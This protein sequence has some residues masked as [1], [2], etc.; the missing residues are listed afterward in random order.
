[1]AARQGAGKTFSAVDRMRM[2]SHSPLKPPGPLVA[3]QNVVDYASDVTQFVIET[4]FPIVWRG[5]NGLTFK[6]PAQV[7]VL[8]WRLGLLYIFCVVCVVA[9]ILVAA[10]LGGLLLDT[11]VPLAT[12]SVFSSATSNFVHSVQAHYNLSKPVPCADPDEFAFYYDDYFIYQNISCAFPDPM[13]VATKV[14]TR[15]MFISTHT[16]ETKLYR[17]PVDAN[18]ECAPNVTVDGVQFGDNVNYAGYCRYSNVQSLLQIGSIETDLTFSHSYYGELV[19]KR[20]MSPKTYVRRSG[21]TSNRRT[22]NGGESVSMTVSEWL[23][24]AGIDI[25]KPYNEQPVVAENGYSVS[26]ALTGQGWS[27]G[28]W[29]RPMLA[30][31][32]IGLHFRY[33][34]WGLDAGADMSKGSTVYCILEVSPQ[35]DWT[36]RGYDPQYTTKTAKDPPMTYYEGVHPEVSRTGI[37]VDNYRYGLHFSVEHSGIIGALN[38]AL[39]VRIL[40]N[41]IVLLGVVQTVVSV[42]AQHV[43][44]QEAYFYKRNIVRRIDWARDYAKYAIELLVARQAYISLDPNMDENIDQAELAEILDSVVGDK[45]DKKQIWELAGFVIS[46]TDHE[47]DGAVSSAEFADSFTADALS[48]DNFA[49]MLKRQ[50]MKM[51]WLRQKTGIDQSSPNNRA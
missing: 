46:E 14:G 7:E 17:T 51:E 35:L 32:R 16:Q 31:A 1:M 20:A 22:F 34:N 21:E 8:D 24:I 27:T 13:E 18:G 50:Q 9:Y 6:A 47:R 30:G 37:V 15:D 45:L 41:A 29:P 12:S 49:R 48:T 43:M 38:W 33:Y 3:V 26:T 25:D 4:Y 23:E 28:K 36:S 39:I 42:I 44:G 40:I 10:F 11:E 5:V 2:H 19:N